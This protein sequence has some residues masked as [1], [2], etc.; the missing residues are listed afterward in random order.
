M[1]TVVPSAFC[2]AQKMGQFGEWHA[3]WLYVASALGA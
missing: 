2:A 3:L 1:R